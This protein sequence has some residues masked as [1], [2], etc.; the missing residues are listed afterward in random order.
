LRHIDLEQDRLDQD[1]RQ[2][3]TKNGKTMATWFFPTGS[4]IR[5]IGADWVEFLRSEKR[6]GPDDPIFPKA[7]VENGADL[8]LRVVGLDRAHWAN[9]NSLRNIFR[10]AF[11]GAGLP[12][13][14]PHSFRSTLV[15]LAYD[16]KLDPESFRG[17]VTEPWPL[18]PA[19]QGEI[20]RG[21]ATPGQ[22]G[23]AC[24]NFAAP[25]SPAESSRHQAR[26]KRRERTR[27]ESWT[28]N[29]VEIEE[30]ISALAEQE[31]SAA[32][33]PGVGSN[34]PGTAHPGGR[35][36]CEQRR[37]RCT[38]ADAVLLCWHGS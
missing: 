6:F 30:A 23:G 38:A 34:G 7:R 20:I 15:Q 26:G 28:L 33:K 11:Q 3:R 32:R 10:T 25:D 5:K 24:Q 16:L 37:R 4:E 21:L 9:A 8:E 19:R 12:A 36:E 27:K 31:Q 29:A 17:M 2:V 13:F 22:L 18:S 35:R 14:N 1:A